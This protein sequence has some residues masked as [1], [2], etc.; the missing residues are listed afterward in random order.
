MPSD[1]TG[2][3]SR[4]GPRSITMTRTPAAVSRAAAKAPPNPLPTT[5]T[6]ASAIVRAYRRTAAVTRGI[7]AGGVKLDTRRGTDAP[8]RRATEALPCP[9][10]TAADSHGMASRAVPGEGRRKRH[11]DKPALRSRGAR[12]GRRAGCWRC[13]NEHATGGYELHDLGT[14]VVSAFDLRTR[15]SEQVTDRLSTDT[16][17]NARATRLRCGAT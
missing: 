16:F 9:D 10:H 2:T 15:N 14:E 7:R 11:S 3:V 8:R 4:H 17:C 13:Q 5:N 12:R 1:R 6:S